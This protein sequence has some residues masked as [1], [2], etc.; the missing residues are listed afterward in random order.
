MRFFDLTRRFLRRPWSLPVK[1]ALGAVGV[2]MVAAACGGSGEGGSG[3]TSQVLLP[4][5][6]IE[7][8]PPVDRSIHS[9][10][11]EGLIFDNFQGD[12][13]TLPEASDT[14]IHKL[15]CVSHFQAVTILMAN[16]IRVF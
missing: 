8:S 6:P 13:I 7:N 12:Y 14:A 5:R 4:G 11:L 9:V 10:P 1:L 3:E 16:S 2:T 15:N